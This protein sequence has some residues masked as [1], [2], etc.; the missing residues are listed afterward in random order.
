[1]PSENYGFSFV[2]VNEKLY[3]ICG[4]DIQDKSKDTTWLYDPKCDVWQETATNNI[5]DASRTNLNA[6]TLDVSGSIGDTVLTF[7]GYDI[8]GSIMDASGRKLPGDP[9]HNY[10]DGEREL[11]GDGWRGQ[12]ATTSFITD[13]SGNH[14]VNN[15]PYLPPYAVFTYI[16]K[17]A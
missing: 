10:C 12:E 6:I 4:A 13:V 17:Y 7:G 8:S 1:M 5:F 9:S 14:I 11:K 2:P 3:A 15:D 16:I